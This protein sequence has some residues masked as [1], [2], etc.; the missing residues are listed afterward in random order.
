MPSPTFLLE[1]HSL[2]PVNIV[3]VGNR[4]NCLQLHFFKEIS[5]DGPFHV[6]QDC[7]RDL[8]YWLLLQE[9]FFTG[10]SV[11]F[12]SMD[13]LFN[14]VSLFRRFVKV[15]FLSKIFFSVHIPHSFESF[16]WFALVSHQK[17]WDR[18]LFL[19]GALGLISCLFE[20]LQNKY[21]L[22]D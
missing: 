14:L 13:F 20:L 12:Y 17:F 4:K 11:C 10:D 15:F 7:K 18:T 19:P 16:S 5:C 22:W 2:Y 6:S 21:F 3:W 9:L 1:D 8:L